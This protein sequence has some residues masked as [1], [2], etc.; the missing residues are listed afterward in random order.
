MENGVPNGTNLRPVYERG[1][2][3]LPIRFQKDHRLEA[4]ATRLKLVPFGSA[5]SFFWSAF[6][7]GKMSRHH[8]CRAIRSIRSR[9]FETQNPTLHVASTLLQN[10]KL[11]SGRELE[12]PQE[13]QHLAIQ[14]VAVKTLI[15]HVY[16]VAI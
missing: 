9:G 11:E 1:I 14:A 12:S 3:I 15:V 6:S 16:P 5:T 8:S 2:G 10:R 7:F 13:I 4:N